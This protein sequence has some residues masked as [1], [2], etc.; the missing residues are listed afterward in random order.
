MK[1]DIIILALPR[2]DGN[3]ASTSFSMACELAREHRVFYVDNP[4]TWK[5]FFK[6]IRTRQIQR[7]LLQLLFGIRPTWR[8][9]SLPDNLSIVTS[10]LVIP[11]KF[12]SKGRLYDILNRFNNRIVS[13]AINK[14]I[15]DASVSEYIFINSFNPFY[16]FQAEGA[17]QKLLVYQ[18]VD[19][20]AE[21]AYV[22]KH[23]PR[24]EN[25][26]I[27]KADLVFVTSQE[28]YRL[29][30]H[31][32]PKVFYLPNAANIAV[33]RTA[34]RTNKPYDLPEGFKG[35]I[36]YVGNIDPRLDY[37]LLVRIANRFPSHL[38]LIVGPKT[39]DEYKDFQLE[40]MPNVCFVGPKR[41]DDLPSYMN[42]FDCAIIPFKCNAATKSIYPLKV[43]EYLASGRPVVSTDFSDD[44]R[45][46]EQ[47]I[48][49][50]A[51]HDEFLAR[52]DAEIRTDNESKR[53]QRIEVAGR[54]TWQARVDDFWKIINEYERPQS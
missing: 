49:I 52:I 20:I 6:K 51:N 44:I 4:F 27:S 37:S 19:N 42:T 22:S 15:K 5:D 46:F 10:R 13:N 54:N 39:F 9:S 33:F 38:L 31:A 34:A 36:G 17:T 11:M 16:Q 25:E 8:D 3:Y 24:L 14:C 47:V 53:K 7:R 21:H 30:Q 35:I 26:M 2:W 48:S 43:N 28:L 23:G 1:P 29:K 45:G 32:G 18:C 50:A 40:E 41:Y 12:L